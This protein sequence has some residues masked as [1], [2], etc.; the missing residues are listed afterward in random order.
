MDIR[1][2]GLGDQLP[3]ACR[4]TRRSRRG[5]SSF[6]SRSLAR[7]RTRRRTTKRIIG[8]RTGRRCTCRSGICRKASVVAASPRCGCRRTMAG[9]TGWWD[10]M[11]NNDAISTQRHRDT[12]ISNAVT[13]GRRGR[14]EHAFLCGLRKW[15]L[16]R[17]VG[18]AAEAAASRENTD[19]EYKTTSESRSCFASVFSRG[20]FGAKPTRRLRLC[21]EISVLCLCCPVRRSAHAQTAKPAAPLKIGVTLHPYYSWT[22]NVVGNLPGYEVRALLPGDIDAGDYQ[23]RPAGHQAARRSRR[24]DR[25]RHRARRFHLSDAEGVGEHARDDRPR[26]RRDA[27]DSRRPRQRRELAHVHLVLERDPADLRDSARA[28]AIAAAGRDGAPAERRRVR[29]AAPHDQSQGGVAARRRE[30]HTRRDRARRLRLSAAGVRARGRRCRAAVA[31]IDAVG[32]RA[33]RH[34]GAAQAREDHRRLQRS[35]VS[36]AAAERAAR[37]GRRDRLHHQP[38][39]VGT[40]H[41]R[42][43]RARDAGERRHDDPRAG[44]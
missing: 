23:P 38:Y 3:R 5:C 32:R 43:V 33:A 18:F 44:D 36:R 6:S 15:A 17:R 16:R 29:A 10:Q 14:R 11:R 1:P 39:R 41:R 2:A 19:C 27:D 7:P 42:Q 12:E 40:V 9:R 35:D 4:Q 13:P 24:P 21:V 22:A 31:R 34:G 37:R 28:R 20:A 8:C 30:D 26:E 25:E